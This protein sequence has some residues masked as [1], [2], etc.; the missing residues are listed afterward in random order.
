MKINNKIGFGTYRIY[1]NN[2]EHFDALMYALNN[3]VRTI[4]TSTNYTNGQS[5]LLIGRVIKQVRHTISRDEIRIISKVGYIQGDS[6]SRVKENNNIKDLV[7]YNENCFHS[8]DADF[9]HSELSLS[10]KR[11]DVSYIDTYLL[12]NPEYFLYT[13]LKNNNSD[14]KK[15]QSIMLERI[16]KAFISLEK[17][18]QKGRILNYGISSNAFVLQEDNIHF[19]PY[20]I[21]LE[22]A[23]L[24][25]LEIGLERS[26]F[27]TIEL[28]LN[29]LEKSGEKCIN[30]C[31]S[32]GLEV[33]VN[34]ALNANYNGLMYRL[35]DGEESIDYYTVFNQLLEALETLGLESISNLINELDGSKHRFG[36]IGDFDTFFNT[37]VVGHFSKALQNIDQHNADIIIELL[38]QYTKAYKTMVLYECTLK[39]KMEFKDILPHKNK[40]L[41]YNALKYLYE[42]KNIDTILVGMRKVKYVEDII[43]IIKDLE[44]E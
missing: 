36:W 21:L 22:L 14:K 16:Y 38:D 24:A 17:E 34:R 39:T 32:K 43:S 20:K 30:W 44:N 23:D 1:E 27:S 18:V 31:K 42:N 10:L 7:K 33:I 28:P 25:R 41:Q 6:L 2:L 11:L 35:A 40:T 13:E 5:E 9:I 29:I 26:H 37:K 19:L 15:I 4:D 8:I 12:H 3:G